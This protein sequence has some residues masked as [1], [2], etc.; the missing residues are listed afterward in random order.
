MTTRQDRLMISN[1]KYGYFSG[2]RDRYYILD[3]EKIPVSWVGYAEANEKYL[4]F[5][6]WEPMYSLIVTH[7]GSYVLEG[8]DSVR[9]EAH[10]CPIKYRIT[11][12]E[13]IAFFPIHFTYRQGTPIPITDDKKLELLEGAL[14]AIQEGEL[15][16]LNGEA[17]ESILSECAWL[18]RKPLILLRAALRKQQNE[19]E[20]VHEI[21]TAQSVKNEQLS[22][23]RKATEGGGEEGS[24]VLEGP[25]P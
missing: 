21:K 6:L 3:L 19:S 5:D 2:S 15:K 13:E 24:G 10:G 1:L 14:Q 25:E 16:N 9:V 17:K 11:P 20:D 4:E 18:R 7:D 22:E 12:P 23:L 8:L